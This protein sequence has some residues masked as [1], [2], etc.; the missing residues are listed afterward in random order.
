M[1]RPCLD[2]K[3]VAMWWLVGRASLVFWKTSSASCSSK[4]FFDLKWFPNFV[5]KLDPEPCS[6]VSNLKMIISKMQRMCVFDEANRSGHP[7]PIFQSSI[8]Q[9]P[10][11]FASLFC[12][13]WTDWQR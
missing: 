10:L 8:V 12:N 4:G 11:V 3:G 1:A 7:I 13:R 5:C 6:Q 2:L 9:H